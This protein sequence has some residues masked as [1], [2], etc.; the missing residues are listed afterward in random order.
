MKITR[1][2]EDNE[3]DFDVPKSLVFKGDGVKEAIR[4]WKIKKLIKK[5]TES[6]EFVENK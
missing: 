3:T 1:I 2:F 4:K 5:S 6:S